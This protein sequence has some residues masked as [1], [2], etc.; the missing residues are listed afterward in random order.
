MF[1]ILVSATLTVASA[2]PSGPVVPADLN[3]GYASVSPDGKRIAFVSARAGRIDIYVANID[4]DR[5]VRV[6]D[7]PGTFEGPPQWIDG[8]RA[9][10]FDTSV[11]NFSKSA[12]LVVADTGGAAR[13]LGIVEGAVGLITRTDRVLHTLG[14][15][16]A[17]RL[18][19]SDLDGSRTRPLTDS[20]GVISQMVYSPDRSRVA[21]IRADSGRRRVFTVRVDGTDARVVAELPA[22]EGQPERPAWSPNGRSIAF[23]V[24]IPDPQTRRIVGS[25]I[26][27]VD[28]V[29]GTTTKLGEH[30]RAYNDSAPAWLPDGRHILLTS[31]RTGKREI[32]TTTREGLSPR[33]LTH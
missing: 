2:Q 22:A 32:W 24:G 14:T 6:T 23:Q 21:Y 18:F 31:D 26:W 13:Q 8:G 9:I 17:N 19:E 30:G 33:Q 3:G 1:S 28:L 5:V 20:T 25:H 4:G 12:I 7:T 11:A 27:T 29:T 15:P 10:A 16:R